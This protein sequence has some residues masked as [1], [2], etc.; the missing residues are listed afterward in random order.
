MLKL[1]SIERFVFELAWQFHPLALVTRKNLKNSLNQILNNIL[2]HLASVLVW[3]L[4]FVQGIRS[5]IPFFIQTAPS[6]RFWLRNERRQ[7]RKRAAR[8]GERRRARYSSRSLINHSR[9]SEHRGCCYH[10]PTKTIRRPRGFEYSRMDVLI[11]RSSQSTIAFVPGAPLCAN[12]L[13]NPTFSAALS[14]SRRKKVEEA[15]HRAFNARVEF[16]RVRNK[17]TR[18]LRGFVFCVNRQVIILHW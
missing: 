8:R 17:R 15:D 11:R 12:S 5:G 7:R 1:S 3:Q 10:V 4:P 14:N 16:A 2:P 9:P 18:P 13:I 6:S